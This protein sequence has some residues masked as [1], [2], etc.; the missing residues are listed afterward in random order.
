MR[1][2]HFG[3][4]C[5]TI[6]PFMANPPP[7]TAAV[8]TQCWSNPDLAAAWT[9]YRAL[10]VRHAAAQGI[11]RALLGF[12]LC[13]CLGELPPPA[14]ELCLDG[15]FEAVDGLWATQELGVQLA[16]IADALPQPPTDE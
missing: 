12:E 7:A 9:R 2:D 10:R 8:V 15:D 4:S 1:K 3:G 16:A 11:E 6:A 5:V 13:K 14:T